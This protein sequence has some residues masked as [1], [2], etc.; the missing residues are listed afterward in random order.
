VSTAPARPRSRQ[1]NVLQVVALLIAFVLVATLGGVLS[2]GL[3]MPVVATTS[4]LTNTSVDLFEE[5]PEELVQV[6]LS[7]K[8]TILAADGQVLATFYNQNR[9][10]VTLDQV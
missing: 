3:V 6:P 1:V 2:A 10:V 7:K 9:I 5:L 4:A 8:S